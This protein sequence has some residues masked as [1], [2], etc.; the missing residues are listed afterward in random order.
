MEPFRLP[1]MDSMRAPWLPACQIICV[2][3]FIKRSP[4]F[5]VSLTLCAG[6]STSNLLRQWVGRDHPEAWV[7]LRE[8]PGMGRGTL[9]ERE[10]FQR[11]L[12]WVFWDRL[13]RMEERVKSCTWELMWYNSA[14]ILLL[15]FSLRF[16]ALNWERNDRKGNMSGALSSFSFF[17]FF[18]WS[19]VVLQCCVSFYCITKWI[20]Y[21]YTYIISFLDF[22]P[23]RLPQSTEQSSLHYTVGSH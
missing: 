14:R 8:K 2:C 5:Q 23:S 7:T 3:L 9:L 16:P 12:E 17:P 13:W 21:R 10:T 6:L 1:A 19:I 11:S 4:Q 20:S 22:L 18:N 15:P